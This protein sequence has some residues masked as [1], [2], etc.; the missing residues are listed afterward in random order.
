MLEAFEKYW[1]GDQEE[2]H[3]LLERAD[4]DAGGRLR[5]AVP[6]A[7]LY[8]VLMIFLALNLPAGGGRRGEALRVNLEWKHATPVVAPRLQEEFK[9][10]QKERQRSKPAL[11]A[12]LAE[13][14]PKP[15]IRQAQRTPPG[16]PFTPPPAP[17]QAQAP[18]LEAPKIEVA[19]QGLPNLPGGVAPRI[20]NTPPPDA[21]KANPFERI[22]G[23]QGQPNSSGSKIAAPK[24][25]V[26]EAVKAVTSGQSGQGMIVGDV[27]GA[28]S[29]GIS[30]AMNQSPSPRR[31][32]ST[33]E[34]LS[35]PKGTD[36]R[37][38]LIQVLAAVKRNWQA[39]MPESARF[40]RQG[41]VAIQFAIDKSGHVPKLVIASP[42]G[43]DALDRAA[44]AGISASNP[45]P[46]LPLE[47]RGSEIRLQLV[48]S[49]NMPR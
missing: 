15:E 23:P 35:D 39:V 33:L 12:N 37:P 41:R 36:F 28:G 31:S 13:L 26:E 7:V 42:S 27:G 2:P 9:L 49:Y 4:A 18:V 1:H 6:G 43:A 34:L 22:G 8:H 29:G 19:Q 25:S 44:V 20:P 24:S 48:F 47:F 5:L 32:A 17:A 46:P 21:A 10:T 40:G 16:R 45:F 38:Y 14:L 30:E 3:F 11:E